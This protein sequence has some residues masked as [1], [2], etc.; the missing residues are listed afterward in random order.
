MTE[1]RT[2]LELVINVDDL[3][4]GQLEALEQPKSLTQMLDLLQPMIKNYDVRQLPVGALRQ[5][6]ERVREAVQGATRSKN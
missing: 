4:L 2:E 3:T 5:L 1:Q 6:I